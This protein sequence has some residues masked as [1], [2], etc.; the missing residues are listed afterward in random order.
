MYAYSLSSSTSPHV[1]LLSELLHQPSCT[2]TLW[3]FFL[4]LWTALLIEPVENCSISSSLT[5]TQTLVLA[6]DDASKNSLCIASQIYL[7]G[8]QIWKV[9]RSLFLFIADISCRHCRV[10]HAVCAEQRCAWGI[11][12]WDRYQDRDPQFRNWGIS[13]SIRDEAGALMGLK[14]ALRPRRWNWDHITGSSNTIL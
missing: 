11:A 2:P 8:I 10:T 3:A 14:T 1:G 4:K 5:L 13:Q 9:R 6:L 7:Q 12:L